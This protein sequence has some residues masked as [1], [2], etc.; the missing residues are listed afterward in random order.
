MGDFGPGLG[1]ITAS[2]PAP[3]VLDHD[4]R[5]NLLRVNHHDKTRGDK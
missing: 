4:I 3:K 5:V 1:W 2:P